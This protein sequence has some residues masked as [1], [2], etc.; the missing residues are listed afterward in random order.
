MEVDDFSEVQMAMFSFLEKRM[1]SSDL[2]KIKDKVNKKEKDLQ[3]SK[4]D[5]KEK[6]LEQLISLK[7]ELKEQ[8]QK[9]LVTEVPN[10]LTES[11]N[12]AIAVAKP[13]FKNSHPTKFTNGDI[14]YGGINIKASGIGNSAYLTTETIKNP[15]YDIS[16]SNGNLITHSL[17]L[18]HKIGSETVYDKL[19]NN[20]FLWLEEIASDEQQAQFWRKNLKLWID[21][22]QLKSATGL[23][24]NYFHLADA[25]YH[26]IAPLFSS[27]LSQA[28]YQ[29]IRDS[30][31][32]ESHKKLREAQRKGIHAEGILSAYPNLA[33]M[34]FG[35]TQPQNITAGNFIRHGEAYLL[36]CTPPKWQSNL[37]PPINIKSIF[38]GEFDRRA[39]KTAKKLQAYL[40]KRQDQNSNKVIREQVKKTVTELIDILLIYAFEVQD[41]AEQTG[42]SADKKTKLK[43]A[44][45]LWLDPY[46][47]DKDFQEQRSSGDWQKEICH[48]FG[49]W[50]NKKL[51]HEKILFAKIESDHWAKLLK[52]PL[53]ESE[54][55]LEAAK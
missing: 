20:E 38:E 46:R 17:F 25:N 33:V 7:N 4:G 39:W 53:Q 8:R 1:K 31:F 21:E 18:M 13:M 40:I 24:Q 5:K 19:K 11:A 51:G 45:K 27:T 14:P 43:T 48:D 54:H 16:H 10:W 52:R 36:P 34:N 32:D 3:T 29:K 37:K 50:L 23:K 30:K 41:L 26:M 6:D 42:W 22:Q 15:I 44:H 55:D 35:G 9:S 49:L 47:N 28:I 12:K 2:F